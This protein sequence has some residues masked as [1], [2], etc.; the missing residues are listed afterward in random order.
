MIISISLKKS[1][2]LISI[3]GGNHLLVLQIYVVVTKFIEIITLQDE[4]NMPEFM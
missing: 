2:I 3:D 1:R 4:K